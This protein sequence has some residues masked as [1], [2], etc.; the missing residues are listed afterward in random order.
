MTDSERDRPDDLIAKLEAASEGGR[1]L[2]REVFASLGTHVFEKRG[3]DVKP[4]WYPVDH[5]EVVFRIGEPNYRSALRSYPKFT[6]SLD[7]ALTLVPEG[8]EWGVAKAGDDCPGAYVDSGSGD[9]TT[10]HY[11]ATPA[12]ALCVAALKARREGGD[13]E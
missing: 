6:T 12:L 3:N 1:A 4:W 13:H 5:N 11:G 7:A 2:D 8:Y 10:V 9:D